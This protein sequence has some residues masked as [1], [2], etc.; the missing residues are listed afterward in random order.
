MPTLFQQHVLDWQCCKKCL[1]CEGRNHA[2]TATGGE[3]GVVLFRGDSIPC[4]VLFVGEAPGDSEDAIGDPFVGPAGK[5]QDWIVV[6]A[7]FRPPPVGPTKGFINLVACYP[8]EQKET[9]DHRPPPESIKACSPRL[10]EIVALANPKLLV[11]VG[12]LAE[13]WVPRLL[14]EPGDNLVK[15]AAIMHPAAIL[16]EKIEVKKNDMIR[17]AVVRLMDALEAIQSLV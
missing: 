10:R 2:T 9:G 3:T 6:K 16:R 13:E 12:G 8:R 7:G 5:L 14:T 1:L 17:L 11:M 15:V 4:D